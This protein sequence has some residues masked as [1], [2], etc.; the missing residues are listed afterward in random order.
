M[1]DRIRNHP[2]DVVGQP[3][4]PP[5]FY[6][7]RH[8]FIGYGRDQGEQDEKFTPLKLLF[9][10]VR[11]RLLITALCCA[12]LVAGAAVTMMQT[13]LYQA[14]AR[15]EVL[16]P[17]AN[18]FQDIEVVSESSDVR[19]FLTAREKLTS[20]ALAQRVAYHLGL[21]ERRDFLLPTAGFSMANIFNRMFGTNNAKSLDIWTAEQRESIAIDRIMKGI[22]ADLIPGTSLLSITFRDQSPSLARDV[23]NQAAQS[24]IDQ[25][26]DRT[27]ATSGLAHKFIENQVSQVKEKLQKSE[28]ALVDYAKDAGITVT[29]N[30]QSLIGSNIEALNSALA[31]AIQERLDTGRLVAQIDA[32]RG[33]SLSQVL[34]SEGLSKLRGNLAELNSLYQRKLGILK[35][36]F[37]EMRQLKAEITS[38][39]RLL[40][41]GILVILNSIELRYREAIN[42]EADLRLKLEEMEK[43]NTEFND[44]NIKYTILKRDVDS[45]RSQY[46]NLI[47]K[48]NEI[49]V[50]SDLKSQNAAIVDA[51]LLPASAYSPKLFVNMI[52]GFIISS[53]IG[54]AIIYIIELLDNTFISVEQV[55]KEMGIS[56][57]G[58]LPL[59]PD[60]DLQIEFTDQQSALSE[61]YR[62]LRTSIQFSGAE[63]VPRTLLVTS[64]EP[65][66]GK[67]TTVFKLG[68]DFAILGTNVLII[69][70]DFRK[71]SLHRLFG[72]SNT[73]GLSNVL[74]NIIENKD[75]SIILQKTKY[76]NVTL[77]SSGTMPSNPADLLCSPRMASLLNALCQSFDLVII[78]APPIVEL[79]DAP[80][81]SR[82]VEGTLLI[83]STNQV[84]RKSAKTALK[85]LRSAGANV[86][87][88]AMSKFSVS[89]FYYGYKYLNNKY[90]TYPAKENII[91]GSVEL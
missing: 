24:F 13:P 56:V 30:V 25:R 34:E 89:T 39:N 41:D 9:Y 54:G 70:G 73:I 51:A 7:D 40:N 48:L 44:K 64:S 14:T 11:Y 86:V 29:G 63:G 15:V 61:A 22:S 45:N 65:S 16:V 31:T 69:D 28:K 23:A 82:L 2:V 52:I 20:R 27:S 81:L 8:N 78:D 88:A 90:Y 87:G 46:E 4:I 67:S 19:A 21:T 72:L 79:S 17:S 84:T 55:E 58:I 1:L 66:E 80:I 85:R 71:P 76:K 36:N 91:S 47:T 77:L 5:P 43:Q 60:R 59:I 33:G 35:P 57:L 68:Q 18:V 62:S 49:S 10:V 26:V 75:I 3:S 12:G 83:I 37:P 53:L 32:G 38:F 42:K 50:S 6:G 74:T